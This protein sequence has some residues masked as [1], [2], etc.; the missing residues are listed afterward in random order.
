MHLEPWDVFCLG[1]DKEVHGCQSRRYL[2]TYVHARLHAMYLPGQ[3]DDD[4]GRGGRGG[5]RAVWDPVCLPRCYCNLPSCVPA[6]GPCRNRR[7]DKQLSPVRSACSPLHINTLTGCLPHLCTITRPWVF[8][9][10]TKHVGF[11]DTRSPGHIP[12]LSKQYLLASQV[13]NSNVH[14]HS[15]PP[16]FNMHP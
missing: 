5:G 3:M 10:T 7:H 4:T 16:Y 13:W 8:P 15:S 1:L 12:D 14:P 9:P 11:Y 2:L 6:S